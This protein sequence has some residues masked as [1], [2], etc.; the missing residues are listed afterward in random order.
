MFSSFWGEL[1]KQ[2]FFLFKCKL[3]ISLECSGIFFS[4]KLVIF[5]LKTNK[6]KTAVKPIVPARLIAHQ[7]KYSL[8]V[9][10]TVGLNGQF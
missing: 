4:T 6:K 8:A 5:D 2:I 1:L 10:A 3:L 7:Q 9:C